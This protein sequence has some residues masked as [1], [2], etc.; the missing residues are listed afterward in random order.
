[1]YM[2]VKF[3]LSE[4]AHLPRAGKTGRFDVRVSC[5]KVPIAAFERNRE[6]YIAPS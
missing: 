6:I 2:S 1:M 5:P 4:Y 3:T